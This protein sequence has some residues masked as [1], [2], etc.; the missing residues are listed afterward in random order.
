[1]AVSHE[2]RTSITATL[3]WRTISQTIWFALPRTSICP[4]TGGCELERRRP[5]LLSTLD[6]QPLS[7][8]HRM[9]VGNGIGN[10]LRAIVRLFPPRANGV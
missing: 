2:A 10:T 6:R 8:M 7:G 9:P 1:M 3:T 5:I 4:I